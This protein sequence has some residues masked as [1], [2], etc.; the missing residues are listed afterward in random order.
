MVMM[1]SKFHRLIQSRLL[2]GAFLVI[3]IFTFVIWGTVAPSDEKRSEEA[4]AAGKMDGKFVPRDEFVQA[5]FNT[6]MSVA[7]GLGRRFDIDDMIDTQLRESAWRRLAALREAKKL[8]IATADDEVLGTL[9]SQPVFLVEGRFNQNAYS[10]F[11]QNMLAPMGFTEAHFEQHVREEITLQKLQRVLQQSVLVAPLDINRTFRSLTDQFDVEYVVLTPDSLKDEPE[12]T[13]DDANSYYLSNSNLFTIPV[14]VRVKYV[15]IPVASFLDGAAVTNEDDALGYYDQ[16]MDS[17]VVTNEVTVKRTDISESGELVEVDVVTNRVETLGFDVVKTNI[18]E[19]LTR[20]AAVDR[21]AEAAVDLVVALAPDRQGNSLSFDDAAGRGGFEVK[22]AGPF[23][24]RDEVPGIDAG[25]AFNAA[26]FALKPNPEEYFSDAVV[27]S[28][29]VYVIGLEERLDPRVPTFE[30]VE[31]TAM[32]AATQNAKS[33]ALTRTAQKLREA[34]MQA[35][36]DGKTF[37]SAV[38]PFGLE[39]M[40]TGEFTV[41][42]GMETNEYSEMLIRGILPRNQG[43]VSD[44]LPTEDG[45]ALIAYIVKRTA[46][47][48]SALPSVA[49][50]IRD[51]VRQQR[52]RILFQEWEKYLLAKAGFQDLLPSRTDD[53]DYEDEEV[54]ED[55]ESPAETSE[56]EDA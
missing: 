37:A 43:E 46:G 51:T 35:V 21:A 3:I 10:A 11:I 44:I 12:V 22:T 6:Y 49:P 42:D 1:I 7:L 13:K 38:E 15:E 5:Y 30:E 48:P 55:E 53:M 9:Q 41:A 19:I 24:L 29:F 16:F 47:D 20:Q 25:D 4:N 39:V 27:G 50:Q 33:E 54:E 34:A 17:F 52:T 8:G 32:K 2:W 28:N 36:A 26:A 56:D 14:Q 23:G 31:E 40:K 18:F 45:S